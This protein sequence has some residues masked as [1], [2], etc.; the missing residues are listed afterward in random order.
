MINLTSLFQVR[1][2]VGELDFRPS[3]VLGQ[4]FLIDRN[5]LDILIRAADLS[6]KACAL[7]IGPGLGVVTER[8]VETCGRVIAVEKDERLFAHLRRRFAGERRLEL[9][10]ADML[11]LNIPDFLTHYGVNRVVSNLPYSVGTRILLNLAVVESPVERMIVTTQEEV[12]ERLAAEP[13]T[14]RYGLATVWCRLVYDVELVKR[15][16]AN[17][18]W[19]RPDVNSRIV[20]LTRRASAE[21][22]K[23]SD[24]QATRALTKLAFAHRRKQLA[25]SLAGASK[26]GEP[27]TADDFRG[28]LEALGV[29]E[30]ARPENLGAADWLNL[31]RSQQVFQRSFCDRRF[32]EVLLERR[33]FEPQ[34][35]INKT[36]EAPDCGLSAKLRLLGYAAGVDERSE[37]SGKPS[38]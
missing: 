16:S 21:L 17:C 9:V 26:G 4:N 36:I 38:P 5:V 37:V 13:G 34:V 10:R 28:L 35:E 18:F 15:V 29:P 2:L 31:A 23:L 1:Q 19:P 25:V 30:N 6:N 20:G 27:I 22:P 12:A 33:N 7:E 14:R 11:T 24:R 32:D 3:K 8:L